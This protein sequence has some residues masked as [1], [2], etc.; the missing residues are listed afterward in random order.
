MMAA[1][2]VIGMLLMA[3]AIAHPGIHVRAALMTLLRREIPALTPA[4][5]CER[6]PGGAREIKVDLATGNVVR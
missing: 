3:A 4:A 2:L 1:G 6:P 5:V